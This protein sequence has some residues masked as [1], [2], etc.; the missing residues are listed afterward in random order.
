MPT[1]V[2]RGKEA[3]MW[4]SSGRNAQRERMRERKGTRAA[5]VKG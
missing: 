2:F 5:A 4:N 1:E 3:C